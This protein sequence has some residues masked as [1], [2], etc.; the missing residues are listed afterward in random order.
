MSGVLVCAMRLGTWSLQKASAHTHG[1]I[2]SLKCP[3]R[4]A[5]SY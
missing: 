4:R 3:L 5:L 2:V 1:R